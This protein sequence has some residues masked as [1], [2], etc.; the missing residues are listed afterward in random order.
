MTTTKQTIDWRQVRLLIRINIINDF[1]G[2]NNP[3]SGNATKRG[4][5]P[6]IVILMLM[7]LLMS[8]FL[9]M[10]H[11]FINDFFTGLVIAG[12]G[13]MSVVALQ[14]LLEFGHTIISPDEYYIIGPHPV[15]SKTFYIAKLAHL[16]AY[17]TV[18]SSTVSLAPAIFAAVTVKSFWAFPVTYL[19][20][21]ITCSFASA[22]LI[23]LYTLILKKVDRVRMERILGYLHMFMIILIYLGI[24]ILPH[25]MK[26][27]FTDIDISTMP[28]LKAV[29][30]YWFAA[31]VRLAETGWDLQTFILGIVGIVLFLALG[32][33]AV[34]YLSLS[35]A[36]SL[37]R[38]SLRRQSEQKQNTGGRL[39]RLYYTLTT[40]EDR[41]VISLVRANF[42]HDT[43]F[44]MSVLGFIPLL[45]FYFIYGL[46]K[47]GSDVRDPLNPLPDT[48]VVTNLLFGLAVVIMPHMM[49]SVIH[50]SKSWRAS[51]VFHA[52]PIDPTRLVKAVNRVTTGLTAIP[53]GLLIGAMYIYLFGNILHAVMHT[54]FLLT[55]ALIGLK[56]L[57]LFT[58]KIPFSQDRSTGS[59]VKGTL[60]PM[61]LA[62]F[63]LGTPI[64]IINAVGYGGYLGWAGVM[65][66]ALL[67]NWV[68][69]RFQFRRVRK[70]AATWEFIG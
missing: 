67:V 44:R 66:A 56:V 50:F 12:L 60:K 68:L 48:Q 55:T 1:R 5:I 51:W 52:T 38:A 33:F 64:S 61:F 45:L 37:G 11:L 36:E 2:V 27:M 58:V 42:K 4:K 47:A 19:H 24:Y 29:P 7:N 14:I 23:N 59:T 16:L 22:L 30:S 3:F 39:S 25:S 8:I 54:L 41:A 28:W 63:V 26:T 65:I 70:F 46:I 62:M 15:T 17:V 18:L 10:L 57:N 40:P 53:A 35:Y 49:Y 34:S 43:Q 20:G 32:G 31:W 69:G 6:G 13:A 21:W 9:G